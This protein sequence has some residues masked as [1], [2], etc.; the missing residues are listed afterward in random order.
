MEILLVLSAFVVYA[1]PVVLLMSAFGLVAHT[2]RRLR[3]GGRPR[4]A[5]PKPFTHLAGITAGGS[6]LFLLYAQWTYASSFRPDNLCHF[7]VGGP[8]RLPDSES[9]IPLSVVCDGTEI[10]PIW[11]NPVFFGLISASLACLTGASLARRALARQAA[12]V[13]VSP[14]SASRS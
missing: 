5:S 12:A 9:V 11:V 14:V 2:V 6:V 3:E 10:V 1:A 7:A 13:S 8:T 4:L